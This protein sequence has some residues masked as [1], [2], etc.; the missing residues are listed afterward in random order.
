MWKIIW[1]LGM[2]GRKRRKI[3][4]VQENSTRERKGE[5]GRGMRKEEERTSKKGD[6]KLTEN[7][8]GSVKKQKEVLPNLLKETENSSVGSIEEV[9]LCDEEENAFFYDVGGFTSAA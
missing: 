6:E 4:K 5:K 2:K 8:K 9:S 1:Y 3:K 7:R